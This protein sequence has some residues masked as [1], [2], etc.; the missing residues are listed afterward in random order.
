MKNIKFFA[1]ITCFMITTILVVTLGEISHLDQSNLDTTSI[2]EESNLDNSEIVDESNYKDESTQTEPPKNEVSTQTDPTPEI[3]ITTP[4]ESS[5]PTQA[6]ILSHSTPSTFLE[7]W[8]SEG[9]MVDSPLEMSRINS[10][11]IT[12]SE[13]SVQ[14]VNT[15]EVN[16]HIKQECSD[17]QVQTENIESNNDNN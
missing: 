14:T 12:Y 13:A 5:T 4:S 16:N 3:I 15:T 10:D 11:S 6:T 17:V 8:L 9:R 1:I 2:Y 7:P